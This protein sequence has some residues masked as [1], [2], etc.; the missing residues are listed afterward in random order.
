M[1][2]DPDLSEWPGINDLKK[3]FSVHHIV[4]YREINNLLTIYNQL[5]QEAHRNRVKSIQVLLIVIS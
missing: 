3:Q 1:L 2:A 5:W 4:P